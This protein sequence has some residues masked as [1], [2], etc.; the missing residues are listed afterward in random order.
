M[1][2]YEYLH[3]RSVS[4]LI[5]ENPTKYSIILYIICMGC[6]IGIPVCKRNC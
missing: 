4:F 6:N 3:L 1:Y 5:Q 2:I